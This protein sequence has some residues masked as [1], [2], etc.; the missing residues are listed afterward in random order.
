MVGS[1]AGH[2]LRPPRVEDLHPDSAQTRGGG[3]QLRRRRRTLLL[4]QRVPL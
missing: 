3:I 2:T 4:G 1:E